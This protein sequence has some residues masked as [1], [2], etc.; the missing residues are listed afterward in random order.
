MSIGSSNRMALRYVKETTFGQTPSNPTLKNLRMTGEG[1][2]YNISNITSEEIRDDRQTADLIQTGADA[3]G[4][5]NFEFSFGTYDDF[6]EAVFASAFS[7][8]LSFSGTDIAAN[9][10]SNQFT[11]STTD[12]SSAAVGQWIKVGG[13]TNTAINGYYKVT[14]STTT[15][16][17]VVAGSIPASESAG[18]T[19]S[20]DGSMIRNGTDLKSMTLQKH[21]QDLQTPVYMNFAGARIGSMNLS[22]ANKQILTGSFS[23]MALDMTT[24]TSQIT[25]ATVS[26]ATTTTPMNSVNNVASI[27]ED[28]AISNAFF[29]SMSVNINNNLR[30]QDAIGNIGHIGIALSR[31]DISGDISIYFE[32]LTQY[33]KYRNAQSFSLSSVFEDDAGNAYILTLPA[34]KFDTGKVVSGSLDQD[35]MFDASWKAI[36]DPTTNCMVQMDRF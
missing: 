4:D 35:V 23:T 19:V 22:I 3:S 17:T 13:F 33:N 27:Y 24:S 36:L 20:I 8:P 5:I 6:I 2:N 14:A 25:G 15:S 29:N 11:S 26:Q 16:I 18:A 32:D 21:F 10:G 31:L 30:A 7:T 1:L 9:S 28:D 34:I 12:L